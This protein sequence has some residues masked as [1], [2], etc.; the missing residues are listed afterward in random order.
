MSEAAKTPRWMKIL[1]VA[2]LSLNL[3]IIGA[4][5]GAALSGG[6]KWRG[7]G[8]EARASAAG[9]GAIIKAL[10]REDK[11]KLRRAMAVALVSDRQIRQS[12]KAEQ[13][14]FVEMMRGDT[15]TPEMVDAQLQDVQSKMVA[16]F[17][18]ARTLLSQ[19]FAEMDDQARSEY[20]D[21]LEQLI[22]KRGRQPKQ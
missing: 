1:F 14:E 16:H 19:R 20:A 4:V 2:S 10:S 12:L 11:R 15:V 17:T 7:P 21:R 18:V 5:G 3:L 22:E 13:R 6:G 8:P 9:G